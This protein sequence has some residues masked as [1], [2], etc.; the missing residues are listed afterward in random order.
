M[1]LCPFQPQ[2]IRQVTP[3]AFC[4]RAQRSCRGQGS[5]LRGQGAQLGHRMQSRRLLQTGSMISAWTC[6]AGVMARSVSD[7]AMFNKIFSTCNSTL[8]SVNLSGYRIGYATNWWANLGPEVICCLCLDFTDSHKS[9]RIILILHC[10]G[11]E[12]ILATLK[13]PS[14]ERNS[15]LEGTT[16]SYAPLQC[17]R[18]DEESHILTR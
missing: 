14:A 7:I 10:H 11:S 17:V 1:E 13:D 12:A 4:H 3:P 9:C 6:L 16:L 5:G 8:P 2:E 15:S 18:H